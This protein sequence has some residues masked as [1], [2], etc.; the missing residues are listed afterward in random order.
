[1]FLFFFFPVLFLGVDLEKMCL[2]FTVVVGKMAKPIILVVQVNLCQNPQYGDIELRVQYIK[3]ASSDYV[4]NMLCTQ[5]V[6]F[7]LNF[8]IQNN[9]C[10]QHVLDMF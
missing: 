10:T 4:E 2:N 7:I 5:T 6:L 9:L 1:M 8:D 3:I